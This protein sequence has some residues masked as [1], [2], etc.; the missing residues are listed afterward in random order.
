[1]RARPGA[2]DWRGREQGDEHSGAEAIDSLAARLR[3]AVT[4]HD[5][6][7]EERAV[8]ESEQEPQRLA[9]EADVGQQCHPHHREAQREQVAAATQP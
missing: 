8:D 1:M 6:E 9:D 3:E 5:V 7:R 4:Q 2:T